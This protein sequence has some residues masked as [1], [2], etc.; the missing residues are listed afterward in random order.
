MCS[1]VPKAHIHDDLSD[2]R[3]NG[4]K[5]NHALFDQT[6]MEIS[7]PNHPRYG[8]HLK[9]EELKELIKP[10]AESTDAVLNW[11]KESGV[12]SKDIET[13]GEWINFVAPVSTAEKMM[14]TT[15]KTYQSV[16]RGDIKRIRALQYSV[17]AE[18][19]EH[20]DMIQPT[21]RFGEMRPQISQV[22]DVQVLDA[23]MSA[24]VAIVNQTCN[25]QITPSCLKELYNFADFKPDSNARTVIGVS[26]FLEQ[27]A[28]FKDFAQFAGLWA[29]WA[30][31]SNFTWTSVNGKT[32]QYACC[33]VQSTLM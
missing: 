14:A 10:R 5:H 7:D 25:N 32:L 33:W 31:G 17:P 24:K 6:L 26:G 1:C 11:L 27:Y 12:A 29:P 19:R 20:I 28:R 13:D 18:V 4:I 9:R 16:V 22:H 2:Q 3:A 30:V 23:V 21:T 15:F 8:Q